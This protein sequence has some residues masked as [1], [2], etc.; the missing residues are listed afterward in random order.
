MLASVEVTDCDEHPALLDGDGRADILIG[1]A[2]SDLVAS[3]A[4]AVYLFRGSEGPRPPDPT[5]PADPPR[6]TA[7]RTAP[8][9]RTARA[10]RSRRRMSPPPPTPFP[11][12]GGPQP[13]GSPD[14]RPSTK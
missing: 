11:P 13:P 1:A 8:P 12:G 4:G 2:T 3:D 6:R 5:P 9:H 10:G 7:P 14:R